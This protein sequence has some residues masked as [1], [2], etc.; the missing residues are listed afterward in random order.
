MFK[1]YL[2]LFWASKE[3]IPLPPYPVHNF[4]KPRVEEVHV[5]Q[6]VDNL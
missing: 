3:E 1:A 5:V 6:L 4:Q 2:R